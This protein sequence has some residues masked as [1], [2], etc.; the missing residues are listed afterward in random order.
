MIK[1]GEGTVL[2][3][4]DYYPSGSESRVWTAGTSTP[5]SAIRYRFGGKEIA[6]QKASAS[7]LA[8]TPAAAAGS[9]YL[10]FGARLYDPRTAAWLSQDPM[11]EKYYPIGPYVYCAGNPVNF[12]D[13][14]GRIWYM[15]NRN[16]NIS[17][18]DDRDGK[19][20]DFDVLFHLRTDGTVD[21]QGA[22]RVRDQGI[23]SRLSDK[24]ETE[25]SSNYSDLLKVFY[26]VAD[27]S[28]V[29]WGLYSSNEGHI[30]K[31]DH[32]LEMVSEPESLAG[33]LLAKIH[34][35]PET[36]ANTKAEFDSMG[37]WFSKSNYDSMGNLI[38]GKQLIK[39]GETGDWLKYIN[40]Y[41]VFGD[42]APKS[43]VYFPKSRRVYQI[44][45]NTKPSLVQ[46]R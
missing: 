38:P 39:E 43:R 7:A 4:F 18:I 32:S 35:H 19:D 12:V 13:P 36:A 10:D 9:P 45:Y 22:L 33:N 21:L 25:I 20:E 16:G 44:N 37:I 31:T 41:K 42:N 46:V 26:Y 27:Y 23:L 29:E 40:Q 17:I 24:S 28:N 3:R 5:Q 1:D 8:G 15:I 34:S 14:E 30:L 6:G 11:A 2:Q